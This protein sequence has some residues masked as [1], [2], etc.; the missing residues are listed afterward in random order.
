MAHRKIGIG[1]SDDKNGNAKA[2]WPT[3]DSGEVTKEY[4]KYKNIINEWDRM[5]G[6]QQ[7]ELYKTTQQIL[8]RGRHQRIWK[9]FENLYPGPVPR[10]IKAA[11]ATLCG[12][13]KNE[14]R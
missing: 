4:R 11:L 1:P 12:I 5:S 7:W 8:G 9:T 2:V 14:D 6:D 3:A 13:D 10:A